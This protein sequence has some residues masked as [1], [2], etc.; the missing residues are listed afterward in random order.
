MAAGPFKGLGIAECE[1]LSYSKSRRK[2][3]QMRKRRGYGRVKQGYGTAWGRIGEE[4]IY[5]RCPGY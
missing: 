1:N 4:K 3:S 2:I 5:I